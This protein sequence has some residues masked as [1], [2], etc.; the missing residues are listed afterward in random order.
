MSKIGNM[1]KS[2]FHLKEEQA[3]Q[4]AAIGAYLAEVRQQQ[5][6]SLQDVAAR[7]LVQA[8]LLQAIEEGRLE[9]LPE[10]VY[11]RGFIRRFAEALGLEGAP[12]AQQFPTGDSVCPDRCRLAWLQ[13]PVAQLRPFHLYLIYIFV[14]VCAVNGL[15]SLVNPSIGQTGQPPSLTEL[16]PSAEPPTAGGQEAATASQNVTAQPTIVTASQPTKP[17]RVRVTLVSQSWIRV[18]ADGQTAFEGVLQ[19]GANQQ[20]AA[21]QQLVVRAGD[22]GAVLLSFNDGKDERLGEPGAVEEVVFESEAQTASLPLPL[23]F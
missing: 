2:G 13:L 11:I 12:L 15:S 17:L 4:L 21:N 20:W 9:A 10:P 6:L 16:T 3:M 1:R 8:R 23:Q 19:P 7:T 22:A 5:A 14:V 18:V